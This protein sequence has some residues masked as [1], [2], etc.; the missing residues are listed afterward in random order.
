M[1]RIKGKNTKPEIT[2]RKLVW[3]TGKR[4]R[5]HSKKIYGTP[6][7]SN[8]K[9]KVAVFIDGCFWHGCPNCYREPT[10]N[11]KFWRNKIKTNKMRRKKV[12]KKLQS[13]KWQV[14]EFWEHDIVIDP[15]LIAKKISSLL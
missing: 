13:T 5:I 6:D 8:K 12:R 3:E 7:I 1:A 2:I 14:L 11:V 15:Q 9:K 4:Y 10:T